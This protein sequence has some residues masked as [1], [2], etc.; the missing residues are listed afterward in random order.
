MTLG[1]I[2]AFDVM[3]GTKLA[4]LLS[5]VV[6]LRDDRCAD[7]QPVAVSIYHVVLHLALLNSST[8]SSSVTIEFSR[9]C[10]K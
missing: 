1:V 2:V 3:R 6:R 10:S 7:V 4:E 9:T 5:Y 8:R